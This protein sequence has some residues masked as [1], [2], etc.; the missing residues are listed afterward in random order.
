VLIYVTAETLNILKDQ[1]GSLGKPFQDLQNAIEKVYEE[2]AAY[3]K[4]EAS[5]ELLKGDHYIKRAPLESFSPK[6]ITRD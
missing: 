2:C 6:K 5:I 1:D 4:C 3:K